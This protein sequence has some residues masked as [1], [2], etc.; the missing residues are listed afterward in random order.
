MRVVREARGLHRVALQEGA[1]PEG[2]QANHSR[3][4][5]SHA[6]DWI[7]KNVKLREAPNEVRHQGG[8]ERIEIN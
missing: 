5:N 4:Q 2:R 3:A 6:T 8:P 1:V 7:P